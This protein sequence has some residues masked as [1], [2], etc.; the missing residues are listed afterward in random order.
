M[1]EEKIKALRVTNA[2]CNLPPNIGVEQFKRE[3]SEECKA[4]ENNL[5]ARFKAKS[6]R[7]TIYTNE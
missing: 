3:R 5:M 2:K 6:S 7:W 4:H 1:T